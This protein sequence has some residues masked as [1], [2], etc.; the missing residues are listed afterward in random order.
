MPKLLYKPNT[1]ELTITEAAKQLGV[2]QRTLYRW[3]QRGFIKTTTAEYPKGSL[4]ISSSEI[5]KFKRS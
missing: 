3:I 1:K 5:R 4:R 2:S